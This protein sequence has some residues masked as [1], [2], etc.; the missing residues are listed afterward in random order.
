M[1]KNTKYKREKEKKGMKEKKNERKKGDRKT[2]LQGILVL[3]WY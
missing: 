3:I 2:K 1:A